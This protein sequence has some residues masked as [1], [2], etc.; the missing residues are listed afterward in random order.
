[1]L[2]VFALSADSPFCSTVAA[3]AK[4]RSPLVRRARVFVLPFDA[5]G[6]AAADHKAVTHVLVGTQKQKFGGFVLDL[7]I[8]AK[9]HGGN[10]DFFWLTRLVGIEAKRRV[11]ESE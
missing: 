1:M 8:V 6:S 10:I 11:V 7:H 9:V 2:N 5:P 3:A 4:Q